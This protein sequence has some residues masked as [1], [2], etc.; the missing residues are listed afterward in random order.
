MEEVA[1]IV[2]GGVK[3][4]SGVDLQIER[5][6]SP[7]VTELY[8]IQAAPNRKSAGGS[9]SNPFAAQRAPFAPVDGSSSSTSLCSTDAGRALR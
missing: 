9:R 5:P 6:G 1:R 3:P 7:P 8:A 4:G 2:S